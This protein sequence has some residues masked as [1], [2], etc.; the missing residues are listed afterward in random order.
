MTQSEKPAMS[1]GV[2]GAAM[3][4]LRCRMF[5]CV[6]NNY[7]VC[8]RCGGEI[9]GDFI[10]SEEAVLW[11]I[12]DRWHRFRRWLAFTVWPPR[13]PECG[14][15]MKRREWEY[16]CCERERCRASWLPF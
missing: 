1:R 2:R 7:N 5:G 16:G 10:F 11:L 3:N 8:D 15:A 9:Y 12:I 6:D 4:R 13:C 14:A